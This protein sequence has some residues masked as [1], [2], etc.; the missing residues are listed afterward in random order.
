MVGS[1]LVGHLGVVA[2]VVGHVADD[3][4]A[5]VGQVDLVG[6]LGGVAVPL[7]PVAEVGARVVVGHG[8]AEGVRGGLLQPIDRRLRD[9]VGGHVMTSARLHNVQSRVKAFSFTA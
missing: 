2:V 1:A 6:A 4:D 9:D 3:L 8:V 7:L 5:A